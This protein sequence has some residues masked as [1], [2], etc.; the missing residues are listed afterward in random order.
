MYENALEIND[1]DYSVWGNLA[2]AYYY[3]SGE[4]ENAQATYRRAIR[5][6]EEQR[7]V[8]PRDPE[9]LAALADY[10]SVVGER[11]RALSMIEQA[12]SMAP[13]NADVLSSAG[14]VYEKLGDRE[15][16]IQWITKA[17]ESGYPLSEIERLP[18][19]QD[20]AADPRYK[21][22]VSKF[23]DEHLDNPPPIR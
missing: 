3:S 22:A 14:L 19:L 7:R 12:L 16:G 15:T 6:A 20:L 13:E 23:S 8:N 9:V 18:E 4:S 17:L 10:Y 11:D 2:S 1:H 21:R 5:M